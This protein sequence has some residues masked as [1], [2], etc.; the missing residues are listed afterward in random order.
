MHLSRD[1]PATVT[2]LARCH[3]YYLISAQIGQNSCEESVYG[4]TQLVGQAA[5]AEYC[6]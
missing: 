2:K 4:L 1:I 5:D 6:Q 3:V